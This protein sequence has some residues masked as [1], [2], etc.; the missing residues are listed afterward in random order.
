MASSSAMTAT[1]TH[2]ASAGLAARTGFHRL[3][4]TL[5]TAKNP[6]RRRAAKLLG[7]GRRLPKHWRGL[8]NSWGVVAQCRR[9][10][11]IYD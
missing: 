11:D 10:P 3:V 7:P 4:A 6:L 2:G 1:A 8:P 5:P 9:G